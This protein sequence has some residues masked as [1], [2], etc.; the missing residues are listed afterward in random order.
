MLTHVRSYTQANKRAYISDHVCIVLIQPY[1][2]CSTD[3]HDVKKIK[4]GLP[5]SHD[6]HSYEFVQWK[7]KVV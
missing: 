5:V 6:P 3:W 4:I 2:I 7:V 1:I